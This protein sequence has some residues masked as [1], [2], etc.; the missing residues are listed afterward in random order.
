[1]NR[2]DIDC[3]NHLAEV[4]AQDP[5][6]AQAWLKSSDQK[7][8]FFHM[9]GGIGPENWQHQIELQKLY[10]HQ[11][12]L[13]LGLHP[14]W[15]AEHD[16][17]TCEQA[18]DQLS[19]LL[20]QLLKERAAGNLATLP[21]AMGE[22]GLDLRPHIAKNS[23]ELQMRMLELQLEMLG[24]FKI[25]AVLHLVRCF[26]EAQRIF[27]FWGDFKL[28]GLVHSFNGPWEQA[29][30]WLK[31]GF[32]ISVGG[33]VCYEKN[34][35]LRKT[36]KEIPLDHLVLET[37]SP[38]QPPPA[39]EKGENPPYSLWDVAK[40]IG[41][42]RSLDAEEILDISNQNFQRVFGDIANGN[43]SSNTRN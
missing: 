37:D 29:K 38:D 30:Y 43:R 14:Y 41:I 9:Q 2:K 20:A 19:P 42:I 22:L 25:P 33:P 17:A 31:K 7:G 34:Q 36:V 16:E 8:I 21:I 39:Y 32:L 13:C 27:D 3:H 6:K 11:F 26:P 5:E 40:T 18:L 24:W 15:V 4:W 28:Q 12:G 10:P 1:M 35:K 23:A